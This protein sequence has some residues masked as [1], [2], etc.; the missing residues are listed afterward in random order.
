LT[1]GAVSHEKKQPNHEGTERSYEE[2]I[3]DDC[4]LRCVHFAGCQRMGAT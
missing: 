2:I 3:T 4:L 1:A